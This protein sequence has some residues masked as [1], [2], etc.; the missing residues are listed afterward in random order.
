MAETIGQYVPAPVSVRLDARQQPAATPEAQLREVKSVTMPAQATPQS[1]D[2]TLTGQYTKLD[3]TKLTVSLDAETGTYIYKSVSADDGEV[4]WQWPSE[5]VMRVVQYFR[6]IE[7]LEEKL[8][9]KRQVDQ[10][11]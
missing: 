9:A 6:R 10:K 1:T 8:S 7:S 2:E 11:A 5:Q 4:V 3:N